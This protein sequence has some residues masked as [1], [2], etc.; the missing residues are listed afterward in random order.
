MRD[1][2]SS[3]RRPPLRSRL[4]TTES[5]LRCPF[6]GYLRLKRRHQRTSQSKKS[7]V[8]VVP[9]TDPVSA[10]DSGVHDEGV[11]VSERTK[12]QYA[13]PSLWFVL[14]GRC[15]VL[16]APPFGPACLP[17]LAPTKSNKTT[18]RGSRRSR[19]TRGCG[20]TSP[21]T[22]FWRQAPEKRRL[23]KGRLAFCLPNIRWP[24]GR[25]R[26]SIASTRSFVPRIPKRWRRRQSPCFG[27]ANS[28]KPTH[29]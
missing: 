27:C 15:W 20:R 4:G 5:R 7:T 3:P 13:T 29:G 8:Q 21:T 11:R 18:R 22:N 10:Q 9:W 6:M 19:A 26:G 23:R 12:R 25:R 16:Q 14:H 1:V 28:P 24:G 2:E 17:R